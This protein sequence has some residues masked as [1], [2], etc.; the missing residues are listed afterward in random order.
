MKKKLLIVDGNSILNRAFYAFKGSSMLSTTEGIPTNAVFGFINILNKYIEEENPNHIGV[1]FDLKAKTFRHLMCEDYKATRKP[2]PHDLARQLPIIKDVL[3]AMRIAILEKEGLEAD[4]IIGIYSK[5]A[6][7]KG[8]DV[9]IL[10]GD[11]DA[12]Q[13]V[14][15]KTTVIIPSTSRGKTETTRFNPELVKE[16]YGVEPDS[17]IDVKALMGDA[18]DNIKGVPGVGEKT[19]TQLIKEYET[20]ENL[21]QHLEDISKDRLRK[22]L[23]EGKESAFLS[24]KLATIVRTDED[25]SDIESLKWEEMDRDALYQLFQALEFNSLIRRMGLDQPSKPETAEET[26][27]CH[28]TGIKSGE[29]LKRIVSR[30]NKEKELIFYA[31]IEQ[32][33]RIGGTMTALVIG[34][35]E[36]LYFIKAGEGLGEPDIA[37]I[38]SPVF[39][40]RDIKLICHDVKSL[41]TWILSYGLDLE[42]GLFD[43]MIAEYLLDAQASSYNIDRLALQHLNQDLDLPDAFKGKGKQ[44]LSDLPHEE[45]VCAAGKVASL[46]KPIYEKQSQRLD[47]SDMHILYH[48]VELPLTLVLGSMEYYGFKVDKD[49]LEEFGDKLDRRIKSLEQTIYMLACEEFNINSPKQLGVIL[50]E[51]IGLKPVKKTKTGYSTNA[52]VL[53]SLEGKHEIIPCILE[54]RQLTKLRSTYAEGLVKVI[55]PVT[56]RI[57]SSFNQTVTATGR[58]SSTEPNLQNIPVR[59]ELGREIRKAF[60]PEEGYTLVDADYSQIELRVLAHITGDETLKRA[61]LEGVDIHTLTASQVFSVPLDQVTPDMRRSAKAVN[62]GIVYGIGDFSL[63]KDINVSRKEAARYIEGYLD[64]YPKV[65]EYMND[66]VKNGQEKGYVETLFH[67]IRYIPELKSS[68]FTVRSFG[69]RVAMNTPIQGSAADIIKIAMVRVWRELK[70]R[71]LKSRLILQV[72]DELL[73]ETWQEELEEV[74]NIMRVG[75]EEAVALSV[76]L[77]VD[78]SVGRNWYEAK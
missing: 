69:K 35:G 22:L 39:M 21:Y 30:L 70:K 53:E 23:E 13:L 75:M 40:N 66:T 52:E 46:F 58:I 76:P 59:T 20:I 62:F 74:K 26:G 50:F 77:T 19:A 10:T 2:M 34:S 45:L 65:R 6:E 78:I 28:M 56:G 73:V 71:K 47:E 24:K 43:L 25:M 60:I 48:D 31:M 7:E 32:T 49:A 72:H 57:H 44:H 14:S 55:H 1:A 12:L 51:K 5:N 16:K 17:L 61:F 27:P 9:S 38:L 33:G 4:D 68:N 18:S 29:E 64:T 15:E 67:R 36:Q 54:Y 42:C 37:R 3:K 63:A 41:Y 8:M 11:R